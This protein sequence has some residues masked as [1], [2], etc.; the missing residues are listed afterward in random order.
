MA[1]FLEKIITG[2]LDVANYSKDKGTRAETL[3]KEVLKK[4]TGLN[5]ERT[6]LSGALH[7]KHGLKSD[8]YIPNE[9]N[10]YA[11]EVKHYK[12]DHLT[13]QM[14]TSKSPQLLVWWEQAVRQGK[15]IDKKPLLIFKFDRSKLFAAFKDMPNSDIKHIYVEIEEPYF[16]IA[17]LDDWIKLEKPKFI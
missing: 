3:V 7:E 14:L 2:I 9:H 5:W 4:Y 11:I 8:L 17:L 15:Q 13:S 6:P 1:H 16:Y 10:L 12:D